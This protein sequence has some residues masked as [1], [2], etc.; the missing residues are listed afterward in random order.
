MEAWDL[1]VI[2][3]LKTNNSYKEDLVI[4]ILYNPY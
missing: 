3:Q 2:D 4:L 1:I